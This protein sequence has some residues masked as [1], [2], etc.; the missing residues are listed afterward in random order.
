MRFVWRLLMATFSQSSPSPW[1]T[2]ERFVVLLV[3]FV[4]LALFSLPALIAFWDWARYTFS[5]PFP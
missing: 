2:L 1:M 4:W 3:S 5:S